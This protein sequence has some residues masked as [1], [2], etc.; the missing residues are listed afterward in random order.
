MKPLEVVDPFQRFSLDYL[1]PMPSVNGL[2]YIL[3]VID[4]TSLFPEIFATESCEAHDVAKVLYDHIFSRYGCPAQILTDKGACFTSK[5]VAAICKIFHVKQVFPSPYHAQ[6]NSC[7]EQFNSTI[8]KA[9][10]IYCTKE[11]DWPQYITPILYSY[12]ASIVTSTG[13]SPYFVLYGKHMRM[14]I[15]TSIINDIVTTPDVDTFVREL[16]PKIEVTREVAKENTRDC[17]DVS[18]FYYDRNSAYPKHKLGDK[19]LLYDPTT[20]KGQCSKLKKRWTGPYFVLA[21]GD[22]Y[23]YKLKHCVTGKE[24]KSFIHSNRLKPFVENRDGFYTRNRNPTNG[25]SVTAQQAPLPVLN[26]TL[27]QSDKLDSD[28]EWYEVVKISNRKK[29]NGKTHFLVHW[30]DGSKSYEPEDNITDAAK[31]DY[32]VKAKQRTRVKTKR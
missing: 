24:P 6:T 20:A 3:V 4:H 29:I 32:F 31:A 22:G 21:E 14:P 25:V 1:G 12:R 15:D 2:K 30:K 16:L 28:D 11:T 9:L 8:L 26:K 19:V 17:H 18:K 27:T 13:F 7:A 5:L 23:V 10:R